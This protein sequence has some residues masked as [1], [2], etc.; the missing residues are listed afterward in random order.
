VC[1]ANDLGKIPHVL[2]DRLEIIELAGYTVEEKVAI[3]R[4][5]LLPKALS[6]HGLSPKSVEISDEALLSLATEYTRESGVRNLQREA[7][8][9]LRDVAM[10]LAQGRAP[11]GRIERDDLLRVLGPPK[12]HDERIE[13][14]PAPGVVTGL[15]WTPTG[16][17]LLIVEATLT[18]GEGTLRLTGRLGEV[19]KES[20]Q[21]ALSLVRSRG[22]EFG[23]DAEVVRDLMKR[24]DVHIHFPAGAVPKDGPSAGVAI[25]TALVSLFA[26]RPARVDIAMTGEI[27]LRGQVL[28][29]GGIR[30]KVLA[31]HR[32]GIRDV[33]LPDRNRKDEPEIPEAARKDM[34]LHYV[35][36]IREVFELVL[37]PAEVDEA[38]AE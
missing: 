3:A 23:G 12:F 28:P 6:E 14:A 13:H 36:H 21:T 10:E 29:V 37:L 24:Y 35:K 22:A 19:M 8:G 30:E 20:A 5:Y 27:T 31:A 4:D 33:I 11:R 32:A 17:R 16:G 7:E 1:T 15:G 2:R 38:A 18:S 34:R 9:L 26:H 25:T